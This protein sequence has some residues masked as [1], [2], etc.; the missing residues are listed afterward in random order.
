MKTKRTALCLATG[1]VAALLLQ[2]TAMAAQVKATNNFCDVITVGATSVDNKETRFRV[3]KGQTRED[4]SLIRIKSIRVVNTSDG[5][6]PNKA[7]LK[8]YQVTNPNDMTK[9]M[10][11]YTV[12]VD[13]R[14]TVTIEEK[15]RGIS[16]NMPVGNGGAGGR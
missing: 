6:D 10:S 7:V 15:T 12:V 16:N 3:N 11:I 8:E 5:T 9:V 13:S 2:G 14:G 4:S 1:A